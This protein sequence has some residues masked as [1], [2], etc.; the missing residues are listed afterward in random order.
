V[1]YGTLPARCWDC[2]VDALSFSSPEPSE[3]PFEQ[4]V[5]V[6]AGEVTVRMVA[7]GKEER[8][9]THRWIACVDV[10]PSSTLPSSAGRRTIVLDVQPVD[11]SPPMP[12]AVDAVTGERLAIDVAKLLDENN[13]P[14]DSRLR[15][16]MFWDDNLRRWHTRNAPPR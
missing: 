15:A 5:R 7:V 4:D 8:E 6:Q 12:L 16:R 13:E 14:C 10:R 2:A 11:D 1:R 9:R 3:G